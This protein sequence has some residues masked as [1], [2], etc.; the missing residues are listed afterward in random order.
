M[1]P[2][3]IKSFSY[4]DDLTLAEKGFGLSQRKLDD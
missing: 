3:T 2:S 1:N 4:D